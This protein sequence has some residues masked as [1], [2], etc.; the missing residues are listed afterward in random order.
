[1]CHKSVETLFRAQHTFSAVIIT[2]RGLASRDR[3][4]CKKNA[5]CRFEKKKK[6]RK[7]GRKEKNQ[8]KKK[9][10]REG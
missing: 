7:K 2:G 3:A 8:K 4:S 9:E 1:M 10:E 5:R 6:K